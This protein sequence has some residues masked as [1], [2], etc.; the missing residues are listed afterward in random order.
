[1]DNELQEA[2]DQGFDAVKKYVDGSFSAYEKR[3][4]DLESRISAYPKIGEKGERGDKGE[5]GEDGKSVSFDEINGL[6]EK[7]V[8]SAIQSL[9]KAKDGSDGLGLA[10]AFID[11][12]GHLAVTLSNGDVKNLGPV[13][14]KSVTEDAVE[15]LVNVSVEKA[16]SLLPK[17]VEGQTFTLS[18]IKSLIAEGVEKSISAL[19]Q[20]PQ[21]APGVDGRDGEKGDTGPAGND[22]RSITVED[23]L[24]TL[25]QIVSEEVSK[26]PKPE[27]G[28]KGEPGDRGA[29][30]TPASV[31][32]EEIAEKVLSQ[33]MEALKSIPV[34]KDGKDG[35]DGIDGKDGV[36]ATSAMIDRNGELVLTMSDGK[37]IQLGCVV[38]KDGRS[39]EETSIKSMVEDAV[40]SLPK[41]KDGADGLGFD[42]MDLAEKDE[43][44]F[45]QFMRGDRVKE[46]RLPVVTD[47]GVFKI[48]TVYRKGDGITDQGSFW[49]AQKD[50]VTER[51]GSCD[52]WR[53]AVKRGQNGKDAKPVP[54]A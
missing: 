31:D 36:G 35:R 47:R 29:D 8:Q 16:A 10:G 4:A 7:A 30:G 3:L 37:T 26:L 21:G 46:F 25:K 38:G 5:R 2:F 34:P 6:V 41:P 11:R 53:L 22:G 51:P 49:I 52:G 48:G 9:P 28:E 43:G 45:L 15:K 24:P 39:I 50:E 19:P 32:E 17:P 23:V 40:S 27:R 54:V 14:G 1:M 13:V 12:D 42:D 18:D 33:V 20:G 44:I